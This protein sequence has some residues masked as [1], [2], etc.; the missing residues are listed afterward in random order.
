[1]N[2]T[3]IN[4]KR[5]HPEGR[6]SEASCSKPRGVYATNH[7]AWETSHRDLCADASL[8]ET[9]LAAV[10]FAFSIVEKSVGDSCEGG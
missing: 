3:S 9:L 5:T 7:A 2:N 8:G 1:M 10:M 6:V 4:T